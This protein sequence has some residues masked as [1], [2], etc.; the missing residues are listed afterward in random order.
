MYSSSI[1]K[2]TAILADAEPFELGGVEALEEIIPEPDNSESIGSR[3][4]S[5]EREAYEKGFNAGEKAGYEFGRKKA[6]VLFSGIEGVLNELSTFKQSLYSKCER[7]MVE[8][9]LSI[10]KKVIQRETVIKEDGVLECLRAALRAVV[11]GGQIAV[12]VNPKD[13]DMVNANRAELARFSGAAKGM[14]V[15]SDETISRGGCAISTNFGEIDATIETALQEV[16]EKLNDAYS[17]N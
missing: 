17:G 16:E 10:A 4:E 12:R 15:E 9:S 1:F 3:I 14:S 5:L 13:L 2:N 11:A 8:L 7:E 6:E